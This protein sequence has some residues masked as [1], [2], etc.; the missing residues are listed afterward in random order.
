M[1]KYCLLFLLSMICHLGFCQEEEPDVSVNRQFWTDFNGRKDFKENR[2]ASGF[3]GFR[4]I[5]PHVYDKFVAFGT[6]DIT[7]TK[8]PK[9]MNLKKPLINSFH[10]GGGVWYTDNKNDDNVTTTTTSR[11]YIQI[12][13]LTFF[14]SLSHPIITMNDDEK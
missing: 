9:F 12:A 8:S 1:N 2:A 13:C 14:P 10:L 6:Y 11:Q 3:V 5:S 4:T 7:H